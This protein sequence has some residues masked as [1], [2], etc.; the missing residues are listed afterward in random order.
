MQY[1]DTNVSTL[2]PMLKFILGFLTLANLAL[3]AYNAGYLGTPNRD[4]HEPTRMTKQ[5]N[6]PAIRLVNPTSLGA[7]LLPAA[8]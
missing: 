5:L 4:G 8:A 7:S 3:A 2:T 6:A 1:P